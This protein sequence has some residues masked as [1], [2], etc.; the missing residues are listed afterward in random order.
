MA[1]CHSLLSRKTAA[2]YKAASSTSTCRPQ[3][4]PT[5]TLQHTSRCVHVAAAPNSSSWYEQS[6]SRSSSSS[7]GSGSNSGSSSGTGGDKQ[8]RQ[9]SRHYYDS[10]PKRG[11]HGSETA[12]S[13]RP[14]YQ[15]NREND[16]E[17]DHQDD[18]NGPGWWEVP[19]EV[20]RTQQQQQQAAAAAGSSDDMDLLPWQEERLLLA[21]AGSKKKMQVQALALDLGL[22]RSQVLAW[23]AAFRGRPKQEQARLLAP[24]QQQIQQQQQQ[25]SKQQQEA[26]DPFWASPNSSSRAGAAAAAPAALPFSDPNPDTGYIPFAARRDA[27]AAAGGSSRKGRRLPAEVLRTLEGVYSRSPWP[28]K[29]VVAGLFDLHRLPRDIVLDWFEAR[30]DM[31]GTPHNPRQAKLL[32][33]NAAAAAQA[34]AAALPTQQ[35]QQQQEPGK[36]AAA[37]AAAAAA[38]PA[39]S[40]LTARELASLR[41]ALPSPKKFKGAK[42]A[43][44]LGIKITNA[45]KAGKGPAGLEISGISFVARDGAKAWRGAWR[46]RRAAEGLPAQRLDFQQWFL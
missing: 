18:E 34:P 35:P 40:R 19:R 3:L 25:Q 26:A 13:S 38:G 24:L 44:D 43:E 46:R 15:N 28:S 42:L 45:N 23:V 14:R 8:Q 39:V 21:A 36:N 17:E 20:R 6:T 11:K 41:S 16:H 31:D 9:R 4:R 5:T 10:T 27:A 32:A 2:G 22:D 33:R 29:E 12:P 37:A 7:G 1:S 30:R